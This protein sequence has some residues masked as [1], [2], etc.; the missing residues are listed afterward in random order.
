MRDDIKLGSW[1]SL[2]SKKPPKG[3]C[4]TCGKRIASDAYWCRVCLNWERSEEGRKARDEQHETWCTHPHASVCALGK[5]FFWCVLAA[6]NAR[7]PEART[8]NDM[9]LASGYAVTRDEARAMVQSVYPDFVAVGGRQA[10][11]IHRTLAA[12]RRVERM[13][14]KPTRIEDST[15]I[16][17][18]YEAYDWT[19]RRIIKKTAKRVFV[20][21]NET[22]RFFTPDKFAEHPEDF[23]TFSINR[24]MLETEG[25]AWGGHGYRSEHFYTEEGM[26]RYEV[27]QAQREA[28][29]RRRRA[30][31]GYPMQDNQPNC[32][33]TLGIQFDC[34]QT[35]VKRAF[36][37]KSRE[38]HPDNGGSHEAFIELRR[39]YEQA[40]RL[41][42][43]EVR[44]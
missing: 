44:P 15:T 30:E 19:P 18:L 39:A 40:M 31:H 36:R 21:D 10:A 20:L 11:D 2:D 6:P 16:E 38:A 5:K 7:P 42:A 4:R 1:E 23:R 17:Y 28:E 33:T 24:A 29:W 37:K 35:D 14:A 3:I 8:W 22:E 9:V 25:H 41:C 43:A 27:E 12:R 13:K 26:R 34:T 32:F